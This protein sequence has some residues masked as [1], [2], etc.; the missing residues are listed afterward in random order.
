MQTSLILRRSVAV[1]ASAGATTAL[2]LIPSTAAHAGV[3]AQFVAVGQ[4]NASYVGPTVGGTCPATSGSS[5]SSS[6]GVTFRHGTRRQAANLSAT[7]TSSDN[8][9]DQ[10]KIKGHVKSALTIKRKS[11]GLKS[12]DFT[13]DASVTVTNT[14]SGSACKGTGVT[15]GNIP[16]M[17]F[18]EKKKGQLSVTYKA[19]K[20]NAL[21][22]FIVFSYKTEQ[23]VLELVNVGSNTHGTA[24]I[25]LKPGKYAIG[26]T[27][28]GAYSGLVFAKNASLS[29][30]TARTVELTASFTPDKH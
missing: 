7:F 21:I 10:V 11:G 9:A 27:E 3:K 18:T 6:S 1:L 26:E 22:E 4:A 24:Q 8:S 19:S 30:K 17:S 2:A 23:P 14:V 5:T 28:I 15:Y 12:L 29:H 20:A 13:A 25:T 16:L